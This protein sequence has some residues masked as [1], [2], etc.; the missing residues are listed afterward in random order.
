MLFLLEI[1]SFA[2][3]NTTMGSSLLAMSWGLEK[4]SLFPGIL[5][6]LCMGALCLYTS[7]LLLKVN[8]NHGK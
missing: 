8:E 3:W 5:I 2:V 1:V 4:T 6:I 7:Y